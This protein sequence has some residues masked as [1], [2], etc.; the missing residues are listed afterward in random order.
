M[1][2]P[3]F[4]V[5]FILKTILIAQTDKTQRAKRNL[6][7]CIQTKRNINENI[8]KNEAKIIRNVVAKTV[9]T[10][11]RILLERLNRLDQAK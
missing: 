4:Q 2:T 11:F 3:S 7:N 10:K 6:K 1:I 5:Y 8:D 9:I